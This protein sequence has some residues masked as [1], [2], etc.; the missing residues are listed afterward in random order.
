MSCE[1]CNCSPCACPEPVRPILATFAPTEP[2]VPE[3]VAAHCLTRFSSQT[4][5]TVVMPSSGLGNAI[6]IAVCDDTEYVVG[7]WFWID[8]L[9]WFEIS[10][11]NGDDTISIWNLGF[12]TNASPGASVPVNS[13]TMM[14]PDLSGTSAIELPIGTSDISNGAITE[15]LLANG[16]V[17]EDKIGNEEVTAAKLG[18]DVHAIFDSDGSNTGAVKTG[19]T[20]YPATCL[21][22]LAVNTGDVILATGVVQLDP[23]LA[24]DLTYDIDQVP[25]GVSVL[26]M[27]TGANP[28]QAQAVSIKT[29]YTC[30]KLFHALASGT[31]SL[32]WRLSGTT[33]FTYYE[34]WITM[35]RVGHEP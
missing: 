33:G 6:P 8:G 26:E 13:A 12:S 4:E 35:V 19:G 34:H 18:P 7:A 2:E 32:H 1:N 28:N 10:A 16:S 21:P 17:T 24:T 5:G 15:A 25:A 27:P 31:L 20:Y 3:V 9:G 30:T 14:I 29:A 22:S 11:L 23:Q